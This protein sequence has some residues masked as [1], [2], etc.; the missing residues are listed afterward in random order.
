MPVSIVARWQFSPEIW[1]LL[2]TVGALYAAGLWQRRCAIGRRSGWHSLVFPGGLVVLYLTLQSPLD[3][4]TRH[5]FSLHQIQHQLLLEIVP[6]LVVSARPQAVL[7]AGLPS[8]CKRVL[9]PLMRPRTLRA[10]FSL[11]THPVMATF[12][13]VAVCWFWNLPP[14][15]DAT[16]LDPPF[17][18]LAHATMLTA[19]LLFWW[20]VLDRRPPPV[21]SSYFVRLF[22]LKV[23]MTSMALFGGYLMMKQVVLYGAYDRLDLMI[24]PVTDEAIGGAILWL[25]G[26]IVPL[27]AAAVI[28]RRWQRDPDW[29]D[30]ERIAG[31][32]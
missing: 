20:R 27:A 2:L 15:N 24:S 11:L 19:G 23:A 28:A 26:A 13:F 30:R 4:L 9:A 16:V 10:I 18:D 29:Q 17:D 31:E 12:L 3:A 5:F 14:V 25:G 8:L 1:P 6:V 22:M 21:G 7:I 32:T